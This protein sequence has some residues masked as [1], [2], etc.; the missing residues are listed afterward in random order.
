MTEKITK[1]EVNVVVY[2]G[3]PVLKH[4]PCHADIYGGTMSA[5]DIACQEQAEWLLCRF[6]TPCCTA[7][8]R[9]IDIDLVCE[10]MVEAIY[11][12]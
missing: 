5:H 9:P 6:E 12:K 3:V 8:E 10:L 7:C 1:N 11:P 4:V 2:N